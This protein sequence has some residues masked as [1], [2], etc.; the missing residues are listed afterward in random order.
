MLIEKSRATILI[1]YLGN[2]FGIVIIPLVLSPSISFMSLKFIA[3][4]T[5]ITIP[6]AKKIGNAYISF[7]VDTKKNPASIVAR[8]ATP[9]KKDGT[10]GNLRSLRGGTEY[11]Y[12]HAMYTSAIKNG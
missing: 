8:Q 4:V 9:I 7:L 12:E 10:K 1:P 3:K 2:K 11:I 5:I 6:I